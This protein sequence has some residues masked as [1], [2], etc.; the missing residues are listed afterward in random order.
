MCL[1]FRHT[2][3]ENG[4]EFWSADDAARK[5]TT[6]W[7]EDENGVLIFRSEPTLGIGPSGYLLP[8]PG[9]N[10]LFRKSPLVLRSGPG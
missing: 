2:P 7:R 10:L 9:G 6:I 8:L 4:F 1:D 5:I 3:A